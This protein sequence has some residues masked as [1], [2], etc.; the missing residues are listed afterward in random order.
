MFGEDNVKTSIIIKPVIKKIICIG[1][2]KEA[3]FDK[4]SHYYKTIKA[5]GIKSL[6]KDI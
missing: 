4:D 1:C 2:T 5:V 6:K 3:Y